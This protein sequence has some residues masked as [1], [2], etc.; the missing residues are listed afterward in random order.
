MLKEKMAFTYNSWTVEI[1]S[2]DLGFYFQCNPPDMRASM[3]NGDSFTDW[4]SALQAA[5]SF[6]HRETAVLA[7]M[8][9]IAEWMKNGFIDEEEYWNLTNFE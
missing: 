6:I 8:G 1:D 2:N 5:R 4:V 7:I 9:I 3:D